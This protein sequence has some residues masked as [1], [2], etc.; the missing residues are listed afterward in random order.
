MERLTH[1]TGKLNRIARFDSAPRRYLPLEV[2]INRNLVFYW[3]F[4]PMT[5]YIVS[6]KLPYAVKTFSYNL[7]SLTKQVPFTIQIHG[8]C[9]AIIH[10][11][12]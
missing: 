8:S 11:F 10:T 9:N 3:Q 6:D 4:S 5:W 2:I 1:K 7:H 12:D